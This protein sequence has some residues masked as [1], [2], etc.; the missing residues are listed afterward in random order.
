MSN[1][2]KVR[3]IALTFNEHEWWVIARALERGSYVAHALV[4]DV[5]PSRVARTIRA[6]IEDGGRR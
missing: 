1:D 4:H 6:A 3:Q 5:K 2:S